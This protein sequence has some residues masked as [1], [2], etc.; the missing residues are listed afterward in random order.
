MSAG[1]SRTAAETREMASVVSNEFRR[2]ALRA[3]QR[4]PYA[5]AVCGTVVVL[6]GPA[7]IVGTMTS[8][9]SSKDTVP[10]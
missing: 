8:V 2:H 10:S 5:V 3:L 1:A 6:G 9:V 4:H 7:A